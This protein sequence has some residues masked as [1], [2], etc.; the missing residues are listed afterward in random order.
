VQ[1]GFKGLY[2]KG[3]HSSKW[4]AAREELLK[5]DFPGKWRPLFSEKIRI[6]VSQI[7]CDIVDPRSGVLETD[8]ITSLVL[9]A[10][11]R[12]RYPYIVT[13]PKMI[14]SFVNLFVTKMSDSV[15]E[16]P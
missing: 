14:C 15:L 8:Q 4:G 16:I 3:V 5:S 2:Q 9:L 6:P 11:S 12:S 10:T 1:N 13:L 7:L